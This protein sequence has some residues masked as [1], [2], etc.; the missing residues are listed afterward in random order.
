ML[1]MQHNSEGRLFYLE[2]IV[3]HRF[4]LMSSI[5][6]ESSLNISQIKKLIQEVRIK[7]ALLN[8]EVYY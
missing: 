6:R 7:G 4:V 1:S 2:D 3:T 5:E 8:T